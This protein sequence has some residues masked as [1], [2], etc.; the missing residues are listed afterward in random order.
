MPDNDNSQASTEQQSTKALAAEVHWITHATFWSQIG[1]AVIG[2]FALVI[3]NGQLDEMREATKASTE[4]TQLASDSLQYSA[5]QF[6]RAQ[7]QTISETVASIDAANAAKSAANTA[8]DALVSVQRAFIVSST[9]FIVLAADPSGMNSKGEEVDA[10]WE[11]TGET[12]TRNLLM[13]SS[14]MRLQ[15]KLPPDFSYPDFGEGPF[16]EFLGKEADISGGKVVIPMSDEEQIADGKLYY[17]W[18]WAT[19]SDIFPH[20]KL[21]I[22]KFCWRITAERIKREQG[23]EV[24]KT[25]TEFCPKNNCA[26]EECAAK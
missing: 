19:Y 6:D 20:T 10:M 17:M 15:S 9:R 22:T 25:G 21:H 5:S 2:I 13:R 11:N 1:L 12:Q 8:R 14:W 18:G 7:R 24:L 16:R 4:A 23:M 3:Y 26:D